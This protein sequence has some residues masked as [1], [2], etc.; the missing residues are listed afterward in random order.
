[1]KTLQKPMQV[2]ASRVAKWVVGSNWHILSRIQKVAW[3]TSAIHG[4]RAIIG[5]VVNV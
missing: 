4:L 2:D 1:M 3:C 5:A